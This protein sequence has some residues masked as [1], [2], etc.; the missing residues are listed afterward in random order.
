MARF[1][2]GFRGRR[3]AAG[4]GANRSGAAA[5][6]FAIIAT[7]F[8]FFMMG[9]FEFG[10]LFW[11]QVSL[12]HAVEQAARTAMAQYTRESFV[13]ADFPTWFTTNFKPAVEADAPNG[14]FGWNPAAVNFTASTVPAATAAGLD[15]VLI[16]ASYTYQFGLKI[17]PGLTQKTLTAQSR[18]PLIGV[19]NSF[20]PPP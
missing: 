5:V 20:V 19:K 7:A 3:A 11:V 2:R 8:I 1:L 15:Y 17:I 4:L 18:A 12:R 6:E 9:V 16:T 14:V 10:R 13:N